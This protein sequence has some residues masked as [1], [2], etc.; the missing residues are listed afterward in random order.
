MVEISPN[1][2][3]VV[4]RSARLVVDLRV[5]QRPVA[6]GFV[7]ALR[8]ATAAAA[9]AARVSLRHFE[10]VSDTHPVPCDPGLRV[11]LADAA[12]GLG[13]SRV[14]IVSGAGHDAAH[15]AAI[16]PSAMIF[17]PCRDGR[18]HDPEE[19]AEPAAIAAGSAVLL[20]AVLA[21]DRIMEQ[22]R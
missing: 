16:A 12:T 22:A 2:A 13:L 20:H 7:A 9:E 17:I 5:S 10:I 6:E 14:P 15:I 19:W 8:A 21:R 1:A 3:N 4:P 11:L 18:S